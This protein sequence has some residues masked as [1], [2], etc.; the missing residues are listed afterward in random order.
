MTEGDQNLGAEELREIMEAMV[1]GTA[2]QQEDGPRLSEIADQNPGVMSQLSKLD[3]LEAA[4]AFAG[5]LTVPGLQANCLRLESLVRLSLMYAT[6]RSKPTDGFVRA[7]FQALGNGVCGW[8]EDPAEDVFVA[9]VRTPRG[10]FR[11][12]EGMWEGNAFYL[13]RILNVVERMPDG[14]GYNELRNSIYALLTVSDLVCARSGVERHQLGNEV[15]LSRIDAKTIGPLTAKSRRIRFSFSELREAG[16]DP[17]SLAPFLFERAD[18][19]KLADENLNATELEHRPLIRRGGQIVLVLPTAVSAAIRYHV[20]ER[21]RDAGMLGAL[22][23]GIATE[24]AAHFSSIP[25]LGGRMGAPIEFEFTKFGGIAAVVSMIDKGRYLN[26]IF[27][28]DHLAD[29]EATGIGGINPDGQR[30]ADLV[31]ACTEQAYE[32]VSKLPGF[33]NGMTL[34]V[35]C[36]VGRGTAAFL[37][38][39]ELPQW[40]VEFASAYDVDTLSWLPG[41]KPLSL[42]RLLEAGDKVEELGAVLQNINGLL[43]LVG[44][45]RS[46]DGHLVPHA[47]MPEE[48]AG[49][50]FMINQNSQLAVRHEVITK[51]D[52]RV[53]QDVSGRWIPARRDQQSDFA[54]D[55][56]A[57]LYGSEI[58]NDEGWLMSIYLAA[59]RTWWAEASLPE[60]T[61]GGLGY[62]RWRMVTVWLARAAPVLDDRLALPGGPIKWQAVFERTTGGLQGVP[63]QL[64]YAEARTAISVSVDPKARTVRTY[65]SADFEDALHHPENIAERALVD[66]MIEGFLTL[67]GQ[68]QDDRSGL[69]HAIMPS[70]L[71]RHSH[72]IAAQH[73]RDFVHAGLP[74]VV[75]VD[76]GDEAAARL[77]LGWRVR[78]RS[79]GSELI[80]K[81]ET[82]TYLNA[83]VRSIEEEL[84]ADLRVFDREALL[85]RVMLNHEAVAA[86][87]DRWRRTAA[88]I[89]AL[90]EDRQLTLATMAEH[91]ARLNSTAQA[92]RILMEMAL[93]EASRDGGREAGDL[94][95]SR[96]MA[97]SLMLFHMG[98]WSD[99][100]RWDVMEPFIRITPLGDVHAKFDFVDQ[101][102]TRYA[103][104]TSDVRVV[105]A[106]SKY[107]DNLKQ[108]EGRVS[109]ADAVDPR[110]LE[111][112]EEEFG[113]TLDEMRV[114]IDWLENRGIKRNE[115]LMR[116]QR[117]DFVDVVAEGQMLD[118][119][120]VARLLE[121]L[122][123]AE[124]SSWRDVP[125]GFEDRDRQPWRFRRRLSPMRRPIMQIGTDENECFLVAPGM[126]RD[127][128]GYMIGNYHRGEFPSYQLKP[129]MRSWAA[130]EADARGA[131]FTQE[132]AAK[133][134]ELGWDAQT[135]VKISKILRRKLDR[136][137]GDVDVLAWHAA[138]GRVLAIECKDLQFRKTFGEISEQLADFRGE[139]RPNGKPDYLRKHLDRMTMLRANPSAVASY[140][141]LHTT[142]L[143][144]E[145]HLVFKNPVPMRYAQSKISERVQISVFEDF[146]GWPSLN[147]NPAEMAGG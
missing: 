121:R 122:T 68:P 63:Q 96:L 138:S 130:R 98:G 105:D 7:A 12:F 78:D 6:G 94:D 145:S 115:V 133:L 123:L 19:G 43:N 126:V 114:L 11:L 64:T 35:G 101:I 55:R 103:Q 140:I 3:P 60:D 69:L 112:W 102:I 25:L 73:F 4:A 42:W 40:R 76:K 44:W 79:E 128:L 109:V 146:S 110:F 89:L 116:M 144:M 147:A 108:V 86:D 75:N 142:Q 2:L 85:K 8:R 135:E 14:S 117:S 134:R 13:Q 104:D 30:L 37:D 22:R 51:F 92:S 132:V 82:T 71:A 131:A 48:F 17:S 65:A 84:C 32:M 31:K 141:N 39:E 18:F 67:A 5:L 139:L 34:V 127:V 50:L 111:A 90:H 119:S 88:A 95:I 99:A 29:L 33:V 100:I 24:Y 9:T 56:A 125:K 53:I 1:S 21:I 59:N 61:P 62:E 15:P 97:K 26:Q 80:G 38:H 72:A 45:T 49:G 137:Y 46:L 16:V 54:D 118:D 10:N 41:F 70:P 23:R 83:L 66:A 81:T 113:S 74:V 93:C 27:V 91:D 124:R 20:I 136:D 28:T 106:E 129:K 58:M 143:S 52:P 120:V 77:D 87:R 107:A 57:P 36:G 47:D